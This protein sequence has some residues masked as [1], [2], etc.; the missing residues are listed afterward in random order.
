M[1]IAASRLASLALLLANSSGVIFDLLS[2]SS[3]FLRIA[4]SFSCCSHFCCSSSFLAFIASYS[5]VV[6][7]LIFICGCASIAFTS[8]C[9]AIAS[10][11][12]LL[13]PTLTAAIPILS[14]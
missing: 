6:G 12:I 11:V 14:P 5:S 8:A 1:A 9:I 3:S 7:F 2:F 10:G 4:I 13:F